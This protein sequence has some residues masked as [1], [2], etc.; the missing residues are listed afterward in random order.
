MY[1][2]SY[3]AAGGG[4]G[5]G[6]EEGR[7]V[8][9]PTREWRVASEW[10]N[11][12]ACSASTGGFYT[13][14]CFTPPTTRTYHGLEWGGDVL[15]FI[16]TGIGVVTPIWRDAENRCIASHTMGSSTHVIQKGP[17]PFLPQPATKC[18]L[19]T[20]II[21]IKKHWTKECEVY[22]ARLWWNSITLHTEQKPNHQME[23]LT[24]ATVVITM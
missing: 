8:T 16:P 7:W 4:E 14:Q 10:L 17:F 11:L 23:T 22:V 24:W 1:V 21:I 5:G 13:I 9:W 12:D 6:Y 20:G 3:P 18:I 2:V 15:K 19:Q